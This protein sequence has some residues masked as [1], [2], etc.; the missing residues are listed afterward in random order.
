MTRIWVVTRMIVD[1]GVMMKKVFE[2]KTQFGFYKV[3]LRMDKYMTWKNLALQL[4]CVDYSPFATITV[5]IKKLREGMAFIDTNNCPWA[6]AFL[7]EN[8]L[9]TPTGEVVGQGFCVYPL[10]KFDMDKLKEVA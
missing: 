4:Y 10:Y 8:G 3:F 1:G 2:V 7:E 9:A 6:P 5:N